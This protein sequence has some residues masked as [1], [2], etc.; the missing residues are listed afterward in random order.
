MKSLRYVRFVA[1]I[2]LCVC[3][4]LTNAQAGMFSLSEQDEIS[5]GRQAAA[6]VEQKAHILRDPEVQHYISRLGMKLARAST[7]PNLPWR[8]RVIEDKH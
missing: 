3:S 4:T 7:R 2:I 1:T 5:I 8:F 6:Q